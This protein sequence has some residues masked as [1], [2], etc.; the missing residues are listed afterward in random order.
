MSQNKGR[1]S[2]QKRKLKLF[3]F[4]THLRKRC[5][6]CRC[7]IT[8]S[9][10]TL[11]HVLPLSLGGDWELKNLQLS[12]SVCNNERGNTNFEQYRNWRRGLCKDLPTQIVAKQTLDELLNELSIQYRKDFCCEL[13]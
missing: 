1:N 13:D 12:C 7:E 4:G 9:T 11:E 10:A 6:F 3:L 2:S 5:C 8:F